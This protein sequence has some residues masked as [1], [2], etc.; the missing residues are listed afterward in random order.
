MQAEERFSRKFDHAAQHT[1]FARRLLR[2]EE[3]LQQARLL[4]E[5]WLKTGW[6]T[7][8]TVRGGESASSVRQ[9]SALNPEF[10]HLVYEIA[11]GLL[12]VL[13][14]LAF[15]IASKHTPTWTDSQQVASAFPILQAAPN[16][17]KARQQFRKPVACWP[18]PA[19]AIL[20]SLQPF[21]DKKGSTRSPLWQLR[22]LT[23][24]GKHRTIAV[25]QSGALLRDFTFSWGSI[26]RVWTSSVEVITEV[27]QD[28]LR[29]ALANK[30]QVDAKFNVRINF[31]PGP[32]LAGYDVM[33][34][35][36]SLHAHVRN[37]VIRELID[38]A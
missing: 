12:A 34:A 2:V 16:N 13:D 5:D 33:T 35:L 3:K 7:L 30:G 24:R 31:G 18:E 19:I 27:P 38:Y 26:E 14:H 25:V 15:A 36:D 6:E 20:E 29:V 11:E 17:S 9:K 10:E 23:N 22:D 21:N 8:H 37:K 28:Y 1:S 32:L 4:E